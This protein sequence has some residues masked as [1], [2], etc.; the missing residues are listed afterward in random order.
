VSGSIG[1]FEDSVSEQVPTRPSELKG[2]VCPTTIG[3]SRGELPHSNGEQHEKS[4]ELTGAMKEA[5]VDPVP[6]EDKLYSLE[7]DYRLG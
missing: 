1:D 6:L 4:L 2:Q 5:I 7:P 3:G